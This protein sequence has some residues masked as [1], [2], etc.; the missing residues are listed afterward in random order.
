ME[1]SKSSLKWMTFSGIAEDNP[2]WNTCPSAF[3]QT[4]SLFQTLTDTGELPDRPAPSREDANDAQTREHKAQTQAR[5]VFVQENVSR[6]NKNWCYLRMTLGTS[7]LTLIRDD[8]VNS[9]G[10][11]DGEKA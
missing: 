8:C 9:K 11:G 7:S 2:T 5:A 3:A 1:T 6:R 10:L 4:K